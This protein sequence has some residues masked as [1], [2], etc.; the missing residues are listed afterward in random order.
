MSWWQG[1]GRG[2]RK[3]E[4]LVSLDIGSSKIACLIAKREGDQPPR[5][6]GV[7]HQLS[8]GMRGGM[9][10]DMDAVEYALRHALE[11]AES[12]AELRID[13]VAVNISGS[14]ISSRTCALDALPL[15]GREVAQSDILRLLSQSPNWAQDGLGQNES[16]PQE[17]IHTIPVSYTLDQQRNI[18]DPRGMVGHM[19]GADLHVI[20]A[21]YGPVRTL[22][23]LLARLGLDIAQMAVSAYA[24]GLACLVEDEVDLGSVLVD[25]GAGTTNFAVFFDGQCVHTDGIPVGG[26]HVTNDIARGLTTSLQAA[27]RLKTLHGHA[28]PS[29]ADDQALIDVPPMGEADSPE[30]MSRVPRAQLTNIIRPRL[31]EIFELI[32]ARLRSSGFDEI[33]GRRMV[34]TGGASQL[35]GTREMAQRLMDKQVRLGQPLRISRPMPDRGNGIEQNTQAER[36]DLIDR[37]SSPAFATV[38][39]LLAIAMQPS[40][41]VPHLNADYGGGGWIERAKH[42]MRHNL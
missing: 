21:G 27:E 38:A 10:T 41:T 35:A 9:I 25:M 31:E 11:A 42:W 23:A 22:G 8:G 12:M 20:A 4:V 15:Y 13:R 33:A 39:G 30:L 6:I 26:A 17:I 28:L 40:T 3:S 2:S 32:R 24:S 16:F 18:R 1:E 37:A 19:L 7:G 29:G 5:I 34:L 36:Q 14:H